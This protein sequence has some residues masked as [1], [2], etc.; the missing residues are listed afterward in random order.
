MKGLFTHRTIQFSMNHRPFPVDPLLSKG[1]RGY[2]FFSDRQIRSLKSFEPFRLP[3]HSFYRAQPEGTWKVSFFLCS[4]NT[5][6]E[7]FSTF[8]IASPFSFPSPARRSAEGIGFTPSVN[9][10]F[11]KLSPSCALLHHSSLCSPS[12]RAAKVSC[13]GFWSKRFAGKQGEAFV[14]YWCVG[15]YL[16]KMFDPDPESKKPDRQWL[17]SGGIRRSAERVFISAWADRSWSLP[18]QP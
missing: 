9:T 1:R 2:R 4:S 5:N 8:Q 18:L 17:G 14:S 7:L 3:P 16:A 12:R 10:D 6:I 15:C 11:E 13:F